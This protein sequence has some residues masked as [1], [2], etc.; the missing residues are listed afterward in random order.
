MRTQVER[1]EVAWSRV[2][3]GVP[4]SEALPPGASETMATELA[5]AAALEASG[6]SMTREGADRTWDKIAA[7]LSDLPRTLK[8]R[9]KPRPHWALRA[10]AAAAAGIIALASLSLGARPGSFLYPVKRSM[11][12]T[13]LLVLPTD[14]GL[15][16]YVAN[17]RLGDLVSTLTSG[18]VDQAPDLARALVKAREAA[19]SAG[20]SK[21]ELATLD[22]AIAREIPGPL[23]KAPVGIASEVR[24]ALGTLLPPLPEP[25]TTPAGHT[26]GSGSG[27]AGGLPGNGSGGSGGGAQ[28]GSGT[29]SGSGSGSGSSGTQAGSESGGSSG[30][31]GSS[32]DGSGTTSTGDGSSDASGSTGDGSSGG[33]S[34][35][36]SGGDQGTPGPS[37]SPGD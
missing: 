32:S 31:T 9:P 35:S 8:V 1:F 7:R 15:R 17:Q 22:S 30:G 13:A 4:V 16:L 5:I 24:V 14:Q 25:P 2:Q 18:P 10:V 11:E 27:S 21:I 3:A 6:G 19:I 37:P 34:G 12:A 23:A 26:S 33:G 29:G 36:T 20:A 28:D